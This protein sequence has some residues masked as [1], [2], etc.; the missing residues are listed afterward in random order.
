MAVWHKG[1]SFGMFKL[2]NSGWRPVEKRRITHKVEVM[3]AQF[4]FA[5]LLPTV[6]LRT[7]HHID[8][9][10]PI[11]QQVTVILNIDPDDGDRADLSNIGF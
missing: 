9:L 10:R 2:N 5:L 8:W 4:D 6:P 7:K 3:T 1:T 11:Y